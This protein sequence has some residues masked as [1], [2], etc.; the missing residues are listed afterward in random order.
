MKRFLRSICEKLGLPML[1]ETASQHP[2]ICCE[3]DCEP[4][5]YPHEGVKPP[6][7]L[8]EALKNKSEEVK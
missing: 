2:Y 8:I 6:K 4:L 7:E 1:E 5:I 3:V